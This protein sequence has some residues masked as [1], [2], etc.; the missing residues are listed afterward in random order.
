MEEE[1]HDAKK[2]NLS[3]EKGHEVKE[4]NAPNWNEHKVNKE[5]LSKS[6]GGSKESTWVNNL[7]TEKLMMYVI[8]IFII[9]LLANSLSLIS[10]GKVVDVKVEESKEA[11]RP[12]EIQLTTIQADCKDCFDVSPVIES[13]KNGNVDITDE[14]VLSS[15]SQEAQE[16][17]LKYNIDKLPT[18]L[19]FGETDKTNLNNFELENDA[20]V[21]NSVTAPF[22][23]SGTNEVKG[24]VEIINIVDTSCEA[25]VSLESTANSLEQAGVS[26]SNT[27]TVEYNSAEGKKLIKEFD[28]KA[29]PSI[30]ISSDIDSY[31]EVIEQLGALRPIKWIL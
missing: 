7:P 9:L 26:I 1:E 3:D 16:L 25:C 4:E 12:A 2:G 22:V 6:I 19:V 31:P 20:L 28:I 15:S 5:N 8:G 11:S 18:L 29:I 24:R 23:D 30:L 27:K 21:F 13:L 14:Q 10:V 17:I